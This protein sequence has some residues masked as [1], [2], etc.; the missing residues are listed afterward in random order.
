MD[1]MYR[2]VRALLEGRREIDAV[3]F[4]SPPEPDNR[5]CQP[6]ELPY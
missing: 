4:T 6:H 1:G 3:C 2:I 5:G